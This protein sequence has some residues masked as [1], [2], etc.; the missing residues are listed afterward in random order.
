MPLSRKRCVGIA[1]RQ[2]AKPRAE[3]MP[4]LE[5]FLWLDGKSV[6]ECVWL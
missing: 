4:D 2:T 1:R 5:H 3:A 6:A